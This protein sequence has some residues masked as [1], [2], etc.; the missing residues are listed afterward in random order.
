M[1]PERECCYSLY[2]LM[3]GL[4]MTNDALEHFSTER[5]LCMII[6]ALFTQHIIYRARMCQTQL[7]TWGTPV[8]ERPCLC[9]AYQGTRSHLNITTTLEI[10]ASYSRRNGVTEKLSHFLKMTASS[11]FCLTFEDF[12]HVTLLSHSC[13]LRTGV[14]ESDWPGFIPKDSDLLQVNLPGPLASAKWPSAKW[15]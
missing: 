9:G 15:E 2:A 4:K 5:P 1:K 10:S 3:L 7:S 11:Q 6:Q 14:T 12:H 8:N 13:T